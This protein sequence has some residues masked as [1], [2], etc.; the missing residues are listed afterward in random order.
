MPSRDLIFRGFYLLANVCWC[1]PHAP[2]TRLREITVVLCL[3]ERV[4]KEDLFVLF[5]MELWD[6]LNHHEK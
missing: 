6:L 2:L 5:L 4:I 3:M 1:D